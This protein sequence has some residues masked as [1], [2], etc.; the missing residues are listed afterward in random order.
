AGTIVFS[1]KS[2]LEGRELSTPENLTVRWR[3]SMHFDGQLAKFLGKTETALAGSVL[4]SSELD[5]TLNRRIDFSDDAAPESEPEIAR[6]ACREGAYLE[7][8]EWGKM[9][10]GERTILVGLRQV[11][12]A[13]FAYDRATGNF[14]AR[15]PGRIHD[16][17]RGAGRRRI[18]LSPQSVTRANEGVESDK[19]PWSFTWLDFKGELRGNQL[20]R[21]VVLK[22]RV[23]VIHGPVENSLI[24][25]FRHDLDG[26]SETARNAV[27][28]KSDQM[29]LQL[30]QDSGPE[31]RE[32]IE[33]IAFG[34]AEIEGKVFGAHADSIIYDQSKE[35]FTLKGKGTDAGIWHQRAPGQP[36]E[37]LRAR[38]IHAV[39]SKNRYTTDGTS[40][41]RI[42]P[43]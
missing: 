9:A 40:G 19:L 23:E 42:T 33:I 26:D 24:P 11:D 31:E 5:V 30:R 36:H 13:E 10:P 21:F 41:I 2:D 15:G 28:A 38:T 7:H 22:D 29:N 18:Q 1:V 27:W 4:K 16:W 8:H 12:V 17:Q 39:P 3:E 14:F 6:I 34:N 37:N 32:W 35:Q 20:D 43:P 25:I